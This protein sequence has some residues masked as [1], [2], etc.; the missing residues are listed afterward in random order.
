MPQPEPPDLDALLRLAAAVP[1]PVRRLEAEN[2]HF[3]REAA[4][5]ISLSGAVCHPPGTDDTGCGCQQLSAAEAVAVM[6]DRLAARVGE[7]ESALAPFAHQ[8]DCLVPP[9]GDPPIDDAEGFRF[10]GSYTAITAGDCRRAAGLLREGK[11]DAR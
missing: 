1:L 11:T 2:A 3:R 9:D 7:L 5:I 8:A 4:E 10:R 6:R